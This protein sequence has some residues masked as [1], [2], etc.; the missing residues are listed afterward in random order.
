MDGGTGGGGWAS[1]RGG[2][3]DTMA[4]TAVAAAAAGCDE[5]PDAWQERPRAPWGEIP[6]MKQGW[7]RLLVWCDRNFKCCELRIPCPGAEFPIF[8]ITQDFEKWD[9][10]VSKEARARH[11]IGP[12][13]PYLIFED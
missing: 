1:G 10:G 5:D 12:S 2:S 11:H 3:E 4:F 13:I 7:V 9:A 6:V 8:R